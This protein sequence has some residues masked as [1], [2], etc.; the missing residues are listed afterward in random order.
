MQIPVV[1]G[2]NHSSENNQKSLDYLHSKNMANINNLTAILKNSYVNGSNSKEIF[3]VHSQ[4]HQA[5]IALTNLEQAKM[6]NETYYNDKNIQGI[7]ALNGVLS[8]VAK[9][10]KSQS[11]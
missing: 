1:Q 7:K 11:I 2:A 3:D 8:Q 4:A 10:L 6:V 9:E 5:Y